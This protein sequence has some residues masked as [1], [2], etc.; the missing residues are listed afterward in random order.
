MGLAQLKRAY[1][2][3]ERRGQIAHMYN[4]AFRDLPEVET[5]YWTENHAW[6]LYVIRLKTERLGID[7]NQFIEE[8]KG[9]G[10]GTSVHFIPLHIH[11]YYRNTFNYRPEDY[12]VS[13]GVYKRI[14]SLPIYSKM[15]SDDGL[16]VIEAV[17]EVIE[18]NRK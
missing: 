13:Y 14:V 11:P 15:S 3:L 12:P 17:R 10:I 5:A 8:L 2:M 16:R 7:R 1:E 9:K 18:E 6:H 4:E